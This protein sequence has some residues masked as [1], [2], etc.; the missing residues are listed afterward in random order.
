MKKVIL[1]NNR[2][3]FSWMYFFTS[4]ITGMIGYTINGGS[5]FWGIVD[6]FFSPLPWIKWVLCQE[7]NLT[8]IKET[9]SW[10]FK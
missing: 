5:T 8:I 10:F 3:S 7:I 6:F 4:I 1:Q 2:A 9:F